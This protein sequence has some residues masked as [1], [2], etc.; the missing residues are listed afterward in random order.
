VE[1]LDRL[2]EERTHQKERSISRRTALLAAQESEI[3]SKGIVAWAVYCAVAKNAVRAGQDCS[4]YA[5]EAAGSSSGK[6]IWPGVSDCTAAKAA[7]RAAHCCLV[8]EIFGNP[9]AAP[10]HF[11][12]AW[13]KWQDATVLRIATVIYE[14][15]AFY[16]LPLLGDALMDAGCDE[17][18]VLAHCREQEAAHVRGCWVID[19]LL[20]KS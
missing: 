2:A 3:S 10:P 7:E 19:L 5:V 11:D 6:S 17:E 13:L 9:F 16:R 20:G 1:V 15:G 8:R 12:P 18:A 14:E 4:L